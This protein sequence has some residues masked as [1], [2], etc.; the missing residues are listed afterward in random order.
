MSLEYVQKLVGDNP[1]VE[2]IYSKVES[3][4]LDRLTPTGDTE[5]PR[6]L[7][8]IVEEET[9]RRFNLVGSEGMKSENVGGH[10][11]VYQ[12]YDILE[13]YDEIIEDYIVESVGTGRKLGTVY[14]I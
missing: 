12:Q 1:I 5:V 3:L 7:E 8:Y 14:F 4:L 11:V 13:V 6:R 9:I 2:D 10:S